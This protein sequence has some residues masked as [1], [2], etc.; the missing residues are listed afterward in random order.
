MKKA[1]SFI[2]VVSRSGGGLLAKLILLPIAMS[3]LGTAQTLDEILSKRAPQTLK[4]DQDAEQQW[5]NMLQAFAANDEEKARKLAN[6]LLAVKQVLTP[7]QIRAT[8]MLLQLSSPK[9]SKDDS[10]EIAQLKQDASE[11]LAGAN[12]AEQQLARVLAEAAQLPKQFS[13]GGQTH[14]KW[15]HLSNQEK[16]FTATRDTN[17]KKFEELKARYEEITKA[18][19]S[20]LEDNIISLAT[21]LSDEN[22]IE[23]AMGLCSVYIRKNPPAE[24]VV[25]KGQ[26]LV[27][28]KE[29]F[30]K[31]GELLKAVEATVRKLM[32]EKKV[33]AAREELMKSRDLIHA[34]IEDQN[35]KNAFAKLIAPL[36]EELSRIIDSSQT[37]AAEVKALAQT[38]AEE[39]AKQL[40]VLRSIAVDI[41]EIESITVTV[42]Q[43][44]KMD[45][46]VAYEKRLQ[47]VRELGM[48]D[49]NAAKGLLKDLQQGLS[50]EDATILAAQLAGAQNGKWTEELKALRHDIDEAHSF[51]E[52]VSSNFLYTLK[53]GSDEEIRAALTASS[54]RENM[55]RAKGLLSGCL[56]TVNSIPPAELDNVLHARAEGIKAT[57][58]A[59]LQEIERAESLGERSSKTPSL[60]FPVS[61]VGIVG[62]LATFFLMRK[63]RRIGMR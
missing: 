60:L 29:A 50:G 36:S 6:D 2:S 63:Q 39:A 20:R 35:E 55:T 3:S 1:S 11:A 23:G 56:K 45:Q 15:I 27:L 26:E 30:A 8:Q 12:Y 4:R 62:G 61:L 52:K 38:D 41:P 16:G 10:L 51:L 24:K 48:T 40:A 18:N 53:N 25:V 17:R 54:A 31:A 49:Q 34:K 32:A 47:A 57:V 9:S 13:A 14:Q 28:L 37:K 43:T 33:W 59:S 7:I 44:N 19:S 22:Q 21:S 42:N 46:S 5:K 58:S